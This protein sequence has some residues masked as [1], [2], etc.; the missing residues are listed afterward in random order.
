MSQLNEMEL[1]N[2]RHFVGCHKNIAAKLNN[3]ANQCQDAQIKQMFQQASQSA[4]QGVQK[5]MGFL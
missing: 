5:L 2:I 3:Y 4:E 1:Q